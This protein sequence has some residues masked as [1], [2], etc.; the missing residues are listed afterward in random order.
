MA[1]SL[2]SASCAVCLD[3]FT[4]EGDGCPKLLPCSH[5]LCESCLQQIPE[6]QP[7]HIRCPECRAWHR[8]PDQGFPTNR[9]VLDILVLMEKLSVEKDKSLLSTQTVL[10]ET[11]QKPCA[12]F[13]L[14]RE[15]WEL[16]CPRCPIQHHQEHN[17]V[18]LTECV[19]DSVELKQMKQEVISERK[20]LQA[21]ET[22]IQ[23]T[24]RAVWKMAQTAIE[25]IEDTATRLKELID[26]SA[27]ELKDTVHQIS[28]EEMAPL[29][30]TLENLSLQSEDGKQIELDIDNLSNC[31]INVWES[32]QQIVAI[33]SRCDEF[34]KT[35]KE[36]KGKCHQ[37]HVPHLLDY[38]YQFPRSNIIGEIEIS[39]HDVQAS[40]NEKSEISE[41]TAGEFEIPAEFLVVE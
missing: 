15:C 39:S 37:Y 7:D 27:R 12:M 16:L 19:R 29:E 4:E 30:E 36:E 3:E 25:D 34:R 32:L 13:C 8:L 24:K 9:Y 33:K 18:S 35:S 1:Y 5:T 41:H 22:E 2:D 38:S 40:E 23:T 14:K 28:D 6:V 17:I 20:S 31:S 21:Y 26:A 10:C 11:H